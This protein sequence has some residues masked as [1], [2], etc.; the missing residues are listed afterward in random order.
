LTFDSSKIPRAAS[1]ETFGTTLGRTL[2]TA[3]DVCK[4]G[5]K[6][7]VRGLEAC[8]LLFACPKIVE[9]EFED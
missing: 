8:R 5:E 9:S 1:D 4:G 3:Q 6:G 7:L 2:I